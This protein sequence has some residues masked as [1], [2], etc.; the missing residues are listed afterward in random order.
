MGLLPQYY[1]LISR[2]LDRSRKASVFMEIVIPQTSNNQPDVD[3][4]LQSESD[5]VCK[6][7]ERNCSSL[8]AVDQS[9]SILHVISAAEFC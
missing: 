9:P 8:N 5:R 6:Y 4:M 2:S 7:V 1:L 3:V